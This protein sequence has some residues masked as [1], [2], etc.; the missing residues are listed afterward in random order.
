MTQRGVFPTDAAGNPVDADGTPIPTDAQG[1]PVDG[2]GVPVLPDALGN[3]VP[4]G[5]DGQPLD[6]DGQPIP[7]VS[8][9]NGTVVD[10]ET[11]EPA[12]F[13]A[14]GMVIEGA[15]A[16]PNGTVT[17]PDGF[18]QPTTLTGQPL[19]TTPDGAPP[20]LR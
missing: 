15:A 13:G 7:G 19:S 11:G 17:G 12:V 5:Q 18:V 10:A 8:S 3:P 2:S 20:H 9:Q 6:E 1:N 4:V 16:A 14:D